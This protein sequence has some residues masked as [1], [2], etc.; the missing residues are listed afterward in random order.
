MSISMDQS[1]GEKL[2]IPVQ[3][4]WILHLYRVGEFLFQLLG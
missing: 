4:F 1:L 3:R 2:D